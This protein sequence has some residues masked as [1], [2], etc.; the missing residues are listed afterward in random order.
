MQKHKRT[1]KVIQPGFQ[2]RLVALFT[3]IGTLALL[4]QFMIVGFLFTRSAQAVESTGGHIADEIPSI[5]LS[6]MVFS[7]GMLVPVLF[8]VGILLTF[9]VAG[10]AHRMEHYLR[11][12]ARGEE[13]GK[14]TIRKGD[15]L[16]S[17]CDAINVAV[18]AL[19]DGEG[20]SEATEAAESTTELR[21]VA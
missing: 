4:L 5:L 16:G 8:G 10:P 17:L 19:R 1:Q 7:L 14:C 2:F 21:K 11:A 15:Q 20:P 13:H 18:T 12:V 6:T 9:R 3:G